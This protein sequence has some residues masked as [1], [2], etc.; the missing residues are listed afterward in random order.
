[1]TE[2][3]MGRS[4]DLS[5]PNAQKFADTLGVRLDVIYGEKEKPADQKAD[6]LTEEEIEYIKWFR[7][8]A[9][10]KEKALVRMI[11]KGEK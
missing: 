3:K 1:M 11:V 9:T 7:E 10:E 6:G 8:E 4:K 2:L 5:K